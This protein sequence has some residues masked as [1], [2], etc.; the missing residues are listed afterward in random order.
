MKKNLRCLSMFLTIVFMFSFVSMT[1]SAYEED[2]WEYDWPVHTPEFCFQEVKEEIFIESDEYAKYAYI[3]RDNEAAIINIHVDYRGDEKIDLVLPTTLGGYPVTAIG[4]Y[5]GRVDVTWFNHYNDES[6]KDSGLEYCPDYDLGLSYY[7]SRLVIPEGY[8]YIYDGALIG[9]YYVSFPKSL[10]Q[11]IGV[12]FESVHTSGVYGKWNLVL[13]E[14]NIE[15]SPELRDVFAFAR[16]NEYITLPS[17]IVENSADWLYLLRSGPNLYVPSNIS[18]KGFY[19][20]LYY[21]EAAAGDAGEIWPRRDARCTIHCAPDSEFLSVFDEYGEHPYAT[22]ITDVTPAEYIQFPEET[23]NI[24]V[25][26]VVDLEAKTYP[27]EAVWTACDYTVSDPSIVQIDDY[28]GRITALKEGTVTVTATHCERGFVD[29]CTVN[30][31]TEPEPVSGITEIK[32]A[33]DTPYYSYGNRDYKLELTGSPNKIQLIRQNGSTTT[34]D[35]SKA[36]ITSNGETETWVVNMCV[37]AGEHAVRAKYG[38]VWD[39]TT[40]PFTVTYDVLDPVYGVSEIRP[41]TDAPY[42]SYGNREY[43][44][45]VAGSPSKIQ[46]V[47][48]NGSTI[49]ADRSIA[50]ITSN[51]E[52]ETWLVNMRVG[53]GE[54]AV[55]AKYGKVWADKLTTFTVTYDMPKAY[56]FNLTY[57]NGIGTFYVVTDPQISKVQFAL[58]NGCT[59][60]YSQSVSYIG[61]DGLRHWTMTRKIATGRTFT[62]RTKLGN[63]W[64]NTDFEVNTII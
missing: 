11:I 45:D 3:V 51:G 29:T 37:E 6:E 13:P 35:R 43:I 41:A 57:E 52:T 17:R 22:I 58:D 61:E 47:C 25:G 38:K 27:A 44:L 34:I 1:A 53:A 36:T 39:E 31:T 9:A 16:S 15:C 28:S 23:V 48:N 5:D 50:Q 64:T 42:Y 59:L 62:L 2:W 19:N 55:R 26:D 46:V 54:H 20:A 12:P 60:T 30:V 21:Y 32:P 8:K 18:T 33:T 4:Y 49:T 40:V 24:Q 63:V 7:V 14:C 10:R 56:S